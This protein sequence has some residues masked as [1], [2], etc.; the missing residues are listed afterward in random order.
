MKTGCDTYYPS[1]KILESFECYKG[2]RHSCQRGNGDLFEYI[3]REG[4]RWGHRDKSKY[5]SQYPKDEGYVPVWNEVTYNDVIYMYE[6]TN[7]R[8]H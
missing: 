5:P 4:D 1:H 7:I 3:S 6:P 2:G 8:R